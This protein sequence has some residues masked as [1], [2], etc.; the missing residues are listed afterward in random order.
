M[1]LYRLPIDFIFIRHTRE[2][3]YNEPNMGNTFLA[4]L[5][6]A[7]QAQITG[8][9]STQKPDLLAIVAKRAEI[10]KTL[11]QFLQQGA[12][13][14][15]TVVNLAKQYGELDGAISYDY[16]KNFSTVGN[17]LTANQNATLMALRKT[18]TDE[19]GGT[20][21]Y[22]NQCGKGYLYSAPM[23]SDAP[24]LIDTDF[25]FGAC[26]AAASACSTNW[27]CCSFSCGDN[28]VC[29]APFKLSSP[30]F[31]DGGTLPITYTCEDAKG[32]VS[33]PLAW[34]GAPSGTVEFA[35]TATTLAVDGKKW[36]WVLYGI[37]AS[38]TSLA[39]NTTG[40]GT[41]GASTDSP[42]LKFYPP[43]SSGSGPRIYTFTLYAL[44]TKPTFSTSP[45]SGAVL[46]DA[47]GPVTIGS[48]QMSVT[49]TFATG[50]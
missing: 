13:D 44:S 26:K 23:P 25:L 14:E 18:A 1:K 33:P 30:A 12:V 34:T 47:I 32:G 4:T 15:A 8:L 22:D 11:K 40:I 20:P 42:D 16:A 27:D 29:P 49:Y 45:V 48:R 5:D 37:P 35:I 38:V 36:N 28:Q 6:K 21:D 2:C 10:S 24:P 39:A 43:C 19:A 31:Q 9:V 50:H 17:S 7:Q 3:G 46:A 41:T